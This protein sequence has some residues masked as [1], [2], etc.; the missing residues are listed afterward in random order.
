MKYLVAVIAFAQGCGCQTYYRYDGGLTAKPY[1]KVEICKGS[2]ATIL[3][4]SSKRLPNS[5]CR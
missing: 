5:E 2:P 3:C 4:E 1:Y